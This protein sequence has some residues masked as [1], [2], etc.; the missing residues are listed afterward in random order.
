MHRIED[1]TE[2]RSCAGKCPYG[3]DTPALLKFMLKD[4]VEFAAAHAGV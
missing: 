4:Y 1:C 3:L 2:C